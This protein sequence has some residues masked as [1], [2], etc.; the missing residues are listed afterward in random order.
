MGE[1]VRQTAPKMTV[2][3]LVLESAARSN[4]LPVIS[5]CNV[6]C[7]F[8]SHGQNPAP[9]DIRRMPAIG[10]ELVEEALSLMD[11]AKPVVIGES[12]TRLIEGEPFVHPGFREIL[13]KIKRK[14]PGTEIRITTNGTLLDRETVDFLA[15]LGGVAVRLSLNSSQVP[16]RRY[17]MNDPRAEAAVASAAL[18]QK[19][20]VSFQGS[21]VAMPH[22]TGWADLAGTLEFFDRHGAAA[23]RVF[24]PGHTRL[25]PPGL[26]PPRDLRHRLHSFITGIRPRLKAPVTLEPPLIGDLRAEVAGVLADSPAFRAGIR[27]GDVIASVDGVPVKSR[28]DAFKRVLAGQ[29]PS[30]EVIRRGEISTC[31]ISKEKGRPSGLVF[32]YDLDPAVVR[33]IAGAVRRRRARRAV[34]LASELGAPALKMGLDTPPGEGGKIRIVAVKNRF[35][36]GSIGCAGLLTVEDMLRALAG[37]RAGADLAIVPAVAFDAR[38]RDIAGRSWFDLELDGGLP[39]EA[40]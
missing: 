20:G 17:L 14:L 16:V 26:R 5:T 22:L 33:E 39:V 32:D 12:V 3:E 24:W 38:G 8:C 27:T 18:L 28:V 4:I 6:W 23:A 25:L 10:I 19:A 9:A 36:G 1:I 40:I 29:D 13:V 21:V 37:C 34:L 15:S 31:I 35:F 11:P 2:K 7:R 30:V